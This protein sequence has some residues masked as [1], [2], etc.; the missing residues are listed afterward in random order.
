MSD[1]WSDIQALKDKQ[2]SLRAKLL[3][4]KKEREGLVAELTGVQ[5][6]GSQNTSLSSTASNAA[7]SPSNTLIFMNYYCFSVG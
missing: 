7:S 6:P 4:R 1:A 3:Q 2:N 5:P